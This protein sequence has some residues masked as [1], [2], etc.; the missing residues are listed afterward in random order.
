MMLKVITQ[1]YIWDVPPA[2]VVVGF[3][4]FNELIMLGDY[5]DGCGV[6]SD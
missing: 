5:M 3:L 2:Y 1:I 4:P 6:W